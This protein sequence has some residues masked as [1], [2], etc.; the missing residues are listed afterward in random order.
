MPYTVLDVRAYAAIINGGQSSLSSL[1]Y[2]EF[3]LE[4]YGNLSRAINIPF[5]ILMQTPGF[6]K[7]YL[8]NLTFYLQKKITQLR[9]RLKHKPLSIDAHDVVTYC[10]ALLLQVPYRYFK[11]IFLDEKKHYINDA[12]IT[13]SEGHRPYPIYI[14]DLILEALNVNAWYIIIISNEIFINDNEK[15]YH[16]RCLK[17]YHDLRQIDVEVLGFIACINDEIKIFAK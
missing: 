4:K 15:L 9:Y 6:R 16:Q 13:K 10:K 1:I 8:F 12:T 14:R 11:V 17:I 2:S 5:S 7:S 3:I